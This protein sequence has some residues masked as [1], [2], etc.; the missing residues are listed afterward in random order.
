VYRTSTILLVVSFTLPLLLS[1]FLPDLDAIPTEVARQAK[2]INHPNN[3]TGALATLDFLRNW[4]LTASSMTF[5]F[6][7]TMPTRK[8]LMLQATQCAASPWRS[9]CGD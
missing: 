7:M 6:V 3:P 5:C 1:G 8:W 4:W 9:G 2:L